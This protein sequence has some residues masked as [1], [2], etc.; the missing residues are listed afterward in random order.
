MLATTKPEVNQYWEALKEVLDPEFPVNV[1]DMGLIYNIEKKDNAIHVTMTYTAVG[2]A[3]TEWIEGDIKKRLLAEPDVQEV[4]IHVVWDP[5]WTV[6][7]LT[8]EAREK[9]KKWGVSSK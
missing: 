6:D 2:C 4:Q 5:P 9:L 7:R 1:V 3:C 8:P